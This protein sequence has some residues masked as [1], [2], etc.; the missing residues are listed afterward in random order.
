[1]VIAVKLKDGTDYTF[2]SY[3]I[4]GLCVEFRWTPPSGKP[5][6]TIL[7]LE[8]IRNWHNAFH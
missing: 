3:H 4:D 8:D 1:M 7:P 2:D 5:Q 6:V